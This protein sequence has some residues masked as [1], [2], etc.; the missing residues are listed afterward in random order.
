MSALKLAIRCDHD[1]CSEE[2]FSL[3]TPEKIEQHLAQNP[4]HIISIENEMA[5][6]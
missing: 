2:R 1:G 5:Y 3:K 6:A 4:D